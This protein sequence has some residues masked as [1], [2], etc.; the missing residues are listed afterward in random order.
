M[1]NIHKIFSFE[2]FERENAFKLLIYITKQHQFNNKH[3]IFI[4]IVF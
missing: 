2:T 3:E 4:K 1:E